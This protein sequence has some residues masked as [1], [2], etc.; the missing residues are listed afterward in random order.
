M[1]DMHEEEGSCVFCY[2]DCSLTYFGQ[3]HVVFAAHRVPTNNRYFIHANV[4][5]QSDIFI[6]TGMYNMHM[7]KEV[8][9]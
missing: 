6:K 4:Q 7:I 8:C 5:E 3:I 2:L 1:S 9:R